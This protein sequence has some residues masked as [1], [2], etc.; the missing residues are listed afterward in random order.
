VKW[1]EL[2]DREQLAPWG[3]RWNPRPLPATGILSQL[4]GV[5]SWYTAGGQML[6]WCAPCAHFCDPAGYR[7]AEFCP[8]H[9]ATPVMDL[10]PDLDEPPSSRAA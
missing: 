10:F 1:D 7:C 6:F 5:S 2:S 8:E 9:I 3:D 4:L